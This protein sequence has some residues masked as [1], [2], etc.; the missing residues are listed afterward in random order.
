MRKV[1]AATL[2]AGALALAVATPTA[3]AP[4]ERACQNGHGTHVAHMTV[5]HNTDGN[6]QAHMSIPHFC[7]E[8]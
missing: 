3:A 6:T 8:E 4:N 5:P 2:G 1:L 7:M